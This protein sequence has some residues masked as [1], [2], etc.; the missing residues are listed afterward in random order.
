MD[1][2]P[3]QQEINEIDSSIKDIIEFIKQRQ[4]KP[5][6]Q[7]HR[8]EYKLL[9][10]SYSDKFNELCKKY[11]KAAAYDFAAS[12]PVDK[13]DMDKET[14]FADTFFDFAKDYIVQILKAKD[15]NSYRA[16]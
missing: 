15:K 16:N 3:T 8:V 11:G 12:S 6:T 1:K 9:F 10:D 14:E 5:V 2:N 7:L 4:G 13:I